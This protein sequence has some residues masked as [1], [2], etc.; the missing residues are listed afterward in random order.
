MNPLVSISER[1]AT[2]NESSITKRFDPEALS[3]AYYVVVVHMHLHMCWHMLIDFLVVPCVNHME[4]LGVRWMVHPA[5]ILICMS[6][7]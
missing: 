5:H 3:P 6:G 7:M 1:N 2:V 4:A